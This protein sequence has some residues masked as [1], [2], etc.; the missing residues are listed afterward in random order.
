MDYYQARARIGELGLEGQKES[1]NCLWPA[2]PVG[3]QGETKG[4]SVEERLEK[5]ICLVLRYPVNFL[6]FLF[7]ITRFVKIRD[8]IQS[9]LP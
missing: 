8:S 2:L 3:F 4:W 6:T 1:E 5:R 7:C 9:L